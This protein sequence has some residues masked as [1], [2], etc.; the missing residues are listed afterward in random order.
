MKNKAI[1]KILSKSNSIIPSSSLKEKI[2][3]ECSSYL[4]ETKKK[5]N[6]LSLKRVVAFA[7]MFV[8]L[9]TGVF[10]GVGLYNENYESIYIDVNPSI[11]LVVNRFNVINEINYLGDDAVET[12]SNVDL[13]G[14]KLDNV[15]NIVMETL[16]REGYFE[17]AEMYISVSS[18][19]GEKANKL[20]EN[21]FT[22]AQACKDDNGYSVNINKESFSKEEKEEAKA[23]DMSPA[24]Y[25]IIKEIIEEDEELSMDDFD[26]FK[27]HSMKDLKDKHDRGPKGGPGR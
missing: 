7:T 20:L 18:E 1:E 3:K 8:I 6:Y 19:R 22:K 9:L 17:E 4:P 5:R 15:L 12:F 2:I 26:N 25:K 23:H 27:D 14:K 10:T 24:K 13:K 11:E 21:I 16:D